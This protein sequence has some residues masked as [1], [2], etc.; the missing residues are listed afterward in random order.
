[1][2]SISIIIPAFNEANVIQD[3]IAAAKSLENIDEVIVIDDGSQDNTWEIAQSC[4]A[5]GIRSI[6]NEGKGSALQKG[7][8]ICNGDIIVFL[9]ADVGSSAVE[10]SKIIHPVLT[11]RCDVCIAKF[12]KA[13]KKG[14]VG[15]V[16]FISRFGTRILSGKNVE[17][18]LSGQ[19]AF[20][21]EVLCNIQIADGYGAEVG[22]TIDILRKGYTIM[23]C[24]VNM[25]HQETGRDL[26]GFIHRGRQAVHIMAVLFRKA[27][28]K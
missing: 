2:K 1:M 19:R 8:H 5:K 13:K 17:S 27:L 7:L 16:K 26:K 14:G 20:K 24:E 11:D 23:E 18:V 10:I 21:S 6:K 25:T 12:G 3:T 28:F 15:M 22:M 4:G 9:D